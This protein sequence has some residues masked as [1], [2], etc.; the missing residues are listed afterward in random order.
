[1]P[2]KAA[3]CLAHELGLRLWIYPEATHAS[4]NDTRNA[5][6]RAQKQHCLLLSAVLSNMVHGPYAGAR[7]QQGLGEAARD[8]ARTMGAADFQLLVEQMAF[9]RHIEVGDASLPRRPADIPSLPAIRNL[10]AYAGAPVWACKHCAATGRAI[11]GVLTLGCLS[12][13]S[14]PYP[15]MMFSSVLRHVCMGDNQ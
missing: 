9:D 7:N 1:M 13:A 3:H 14:R 10:P 12:T 11:R 2:F 4:W 5:V 15:S 8:L 6:R